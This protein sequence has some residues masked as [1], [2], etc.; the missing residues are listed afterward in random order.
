MLEEGGEQWWRREKGRRGNVEG[1]R[2]ERSGGDT[3]VV[4]IQDIKRK[5]TEV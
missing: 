2:G 5:L 4:A 3:M 1:R